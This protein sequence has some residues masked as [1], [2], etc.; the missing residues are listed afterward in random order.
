MLINTILHENATRFGD[1]DV[2]KKLLITNDKIVAI[3]KNS[4]KLEV[5]TLTNQLH[6]C[7][8]SEQQRIA[9]KMK[10]TIYASVPIAGSY[11]DMMQHQ[12]DS[13]Q[14]HACWCH[15]KQAQIGFV[16]CQRAAAAAATATTMATTTTMTTRVA[17]GGIEDDN[18]DGD[19]DDDNENDSDSD[20]DCHSDSV[21]LDNCTDSDGDDVSSGINS[22]AVTENVSIDNEVTMVLNGAT[23]SKIM[24]NIANNNNNNNNQKQSKLTKSNNF[25]RAMI[26]RRFQAA[27][28]LFYKHRLV[29]LWE[30]A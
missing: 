19:V 9:N 23:F 14:Q 26:C 5:K 28:I 8:N 24:K 3:T 22:K 1:A 12:R 11:V 20:S 15:P 18:V 17:V 30:S 2:P 4:K 27:W 7:L 16:K 13:R 29:Q 10:E 25:L 21:A 6:D